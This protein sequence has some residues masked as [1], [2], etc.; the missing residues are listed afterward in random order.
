MEQHVKAENK[1]E[2]EMQRRTSTSVFD[3]SGELKREH[4]QSLSHDG[5]VYLG[6]YL[7]IAGVEWAPEPNGSDH[8]AW[9]A[10]L[11]EY[12]AKLPPDNTF[13]GI[14]GGPLND[15]TAKILHAVAMLY[16]TGMREGIQGYEARSAARADKFLR[17]GGGSGTMWNTDTVREEICGLI[18]KHNDPREIAADKRLQVFEDA[19]R[20]ETV[21]FFPNTGEGL[22]LLKERCKPELF[23]TGWAK[24]KDNFRQWMVTRGWK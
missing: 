18:Y 11:V 5:Q 3:G 2:R 24:S 12:I 8:C 4:A 17:E 14:V 16:C 22:A 13:G 20:Y 6:E 7:H 23:H 21:R 15:R 10:R 9:L 19:L 1:I